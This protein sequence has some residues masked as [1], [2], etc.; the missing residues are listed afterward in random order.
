MY[1]IFVQIAKLS[2]LHLISMVLCCVVVGLEV[3]ESSEGGDWSELY[4]S[5]RLCYC[6]SLGENILCCK[7]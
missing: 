6:A 1:A 7:I 5:S 4:V 3:V 2:N